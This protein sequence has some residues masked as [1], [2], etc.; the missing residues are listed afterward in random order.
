MALIKCPECGNMISDKAVK[1]PKCGYPVGQGFTP[2]PAPIITDKDVEES[3]ETPP[4]RK[5]L[6]AV[7]G[8][9]LAAIVAVI[10]LLLRSSDSQDAFTDDSPS[11]MV[12]K[13]VEEKEKTY[14]L[15]ITEGGFL[16]IRETPSAS[17]AILG[18]LVTGGAAAE[19]LEK[20]GDWYKIRLDNIEGYV[21]GTY[22]FVGNEKDIEEYKKI[23]RMPT[24]RQVYGLW[25]R[26]YKKAGFDAEFFKRTV[27][28]KNMSALCGSI[29]G[30]K[31]LKCLYESYYDTGYEAPGYAGGYAVYYGVNVSGVK[32]SKTPTGYRASFSSD[33]TRACG[34]E[35]LYNA[36]LSCS[37]GCFKTYFKDKG[38]AETFL[39]QL[40]NSGK[41]KKENYDG[42]TYYSTSS[43]R[44]MGASD[45]EHENG[46]YIV[47]VTVPTT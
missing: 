16:N 34:I 41:W 37:E 40:R 32:S 18:K 15:S 43:P 29:L 27:T 30:L 2:S 7:I 38:D 45:V 17:A 23:V 12:S 36:D 10:V 28:D 24:Y 21:K 35:I 19:V 13:Q 22:V 5:W 25:E 9:L 3:L 1:C 42:K 46:W 47:C 6:Y 8:I 20:E 33:D 31:Y 4:S 44:S 26:V 39:G 14:A 11:E